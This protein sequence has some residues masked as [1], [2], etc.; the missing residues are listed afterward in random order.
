MVTCAQGWQSPSVGV[1]LKHTM[2]SA[3]W[4][5]VY[6][7]CMNEA[8]W[9]GLAYMRYMLYFLA[10]LFLVSDLQAFPGTRTVAVVF[11]AIGLVIAAFSYGA[12]RVNDT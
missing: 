7:Y 5:L 4:L 8:T 9:E 3:N 12:G 11:L 6:G 1:P 10:G 2:K